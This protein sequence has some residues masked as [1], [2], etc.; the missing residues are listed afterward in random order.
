L[1]LSLRASRRRKIFP[2]RAGI[3]LFSR[4]RARPENPPAAIRFPP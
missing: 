3:R 1:R 2:I 4:M